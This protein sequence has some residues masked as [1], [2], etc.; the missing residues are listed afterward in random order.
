MPQYEW[1][2]RHARKKHP[3]LAR[4]RKTLKT[5]RKYGMF[6]GFR[7]SMSPYTEPTPAK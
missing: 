4:V 2:S 1:E 3:R 7:E 5:V 6:C